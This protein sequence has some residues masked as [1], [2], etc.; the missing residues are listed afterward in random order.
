MRGF[1]NRSA[2]HDLATPLPRGDDVAIVQA[3][4]GGRPRLGASP[5]GALL[6]A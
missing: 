1:V 6:M 5:S 4:S 2:M 3:L